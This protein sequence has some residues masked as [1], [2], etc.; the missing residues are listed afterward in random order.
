MKKKI[1]FVTL[2]LL[3]FFGIFSLKHLSTENYNLRFIKDVVPNPFNWKGFVKKNFFPKNE[4]KI[5][6]KIL[7]KSDGINAFNLKSD[8]II[9][10]Y[11]E[12]KYGLSIGPYNYGKKTAI[13]KPDLIVEIISINLNKNENCLRKTFKQNIKVIISSLDNNCNN[14]IYFQGKVFEKKKPNEPVYFYFGK[15]YNKSVVNKSNLLVLPVSTFYNYSSN[16]LSINQ[17]SVTNLEYISNLS[18]VPQSYK[19]GWSSILSKSIKNMGNLFGDFEIIHDYSFQ[20]LDLSKYNLII[21]PMHQEYVSNKFLNK[22]FNFLSEN[23]KNKALSIGGAN[24]LRKIDFVKRDGLINFVYFDNEY[25]DPKKYNFNTYDYGKNSNCILNS[26]LEN[27]KTIDLG[28]ISEPLIEKDT[29]YYFYDIQCD[30]NKKIPLIS[31]TK[32]NDN[33]KLIHIL[34]DTVGLNILNIKK[35]REKINSFFSEEIKN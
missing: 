4:K 6:E 30:N 1:V 35:L 24:F 14:G 27:S 13:N 10:I 23:K 28:D 29:N 19:I 32:Y 8:S 5:H 18:E 12:N 3:F 15:K 21:F 2:I 9:Y 25:N 17:I 20:D 7:I 33:G 11:S 16:S 26:N 31:S 22:L 34:S